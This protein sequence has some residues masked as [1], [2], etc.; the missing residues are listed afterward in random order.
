MVL[1]S[2]KARHLWNWTPATP[3]HAILD[4]IASH[5]LAHPRWLELSTPL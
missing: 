1:D 5:A 2:T 3:V 4:E